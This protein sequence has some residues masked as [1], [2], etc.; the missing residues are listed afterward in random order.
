MKV[1]VCKAYGSADV[2][3]LEE[4]PMPVCKDNEILI[5]I[6]AATVSAGDTR[7][8]RGTRE[9]LPLWP[10][11][12]LAMGIQRPRHPI[13]GVELAGEVV[14]VGRTA[15]RFREGDAVYAAS[16]MG[17]GAYA[18]YKAMSEHGAVAMK[19][20]NLTYEEAAAV[21]VGALSAL[22]FLRKGGIQRGQQVLIYGASGSVGT[23]AVQLAKHFGAV[24]TAVCST[25]NVSMMKE[26]GAD[27]V[28]DY[29]QEDFTTIDTKVDMI[30]DTVGKTTFSS[31]RRLLQPRGRYILAVFNFKEVGQMLWTSLFSGQK[32]VCGVADERIEDLE[33]LRELI[34]AGAVKP[35]ID[36][37]YTLDQIR[38]AHRYVEQGHK[39]GNVVI[40]MDNDDNL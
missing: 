22:F 15:T 7:A 20:A 1:V 8:R 29:S 21:P 18:E 30:L 32:V 36:R 4:V 19:P 26:L 24:V 33:L 31:C 40:T 2:L 5:R 14:Q 35:V 17:W 25:G 39:K 38:E 28:I 10:L 3:Q 34:E 11:S 37:S 23:Y 13:L 16:G 12:K 6:R 27:R 9:S